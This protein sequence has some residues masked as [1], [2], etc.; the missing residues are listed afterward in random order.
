MDRVRDKETE[1]LFETYLILKKPIPYIPKNDTKNTVKMQ[2]DSRLHDGGTTKWTT[3]A[4][5]FQV[6]L[7]PL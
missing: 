4:L 6:L 5:R 1:V 7:P 2:Q 3:L